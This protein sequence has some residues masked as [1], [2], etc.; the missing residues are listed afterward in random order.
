VSANSVSTLDLFTGREL[1]A[2]PEE[3]GV[4]ASVAF[5][6]DGRL[7]ATGGLEGSILV[8]NAPQPRPLAASQ[9]ADAN[10]MASWWDDL[11]DKDAA[12]AY[13]AARRLLLEG[14]ATVGF[15]RERLRP[16]SHPAQA[17]GLA[18]MIADLDNDSLRVRE[19]ASRKLAALGD[20]EFLRDSLSKARSLEV[21]ARLTEILS[22][23]AKAAI[24]DPQELRAVRAVRILDLIGD[25]P[26][27]ELLSQLAAGGPGRLTREAA[28]AL[29]RRNPPASMPASAPAP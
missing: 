18:G 2:L 24:T 12:K 26:A 1:A 4:A 20:D 29:A 5:S 14:P 13:A 19:E 23:L 22:N 7:L 11:A 21:R 9:P 8:W 10:E 17:P 6:P 27:R 28:A 25:R 3:A 15:L 16:I